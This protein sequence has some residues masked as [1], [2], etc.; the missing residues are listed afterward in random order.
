MIGMEDPS[1]QWAVSA[2]GRWSCFVLKAN[3][4]SHEKRDIA[5]FSHDL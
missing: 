4:V 5:A 1:P 2:S 3:P